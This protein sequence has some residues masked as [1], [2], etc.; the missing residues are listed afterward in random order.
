MKQHLLS[1]AALALSLQPATAE[2]PTTTISEPT[3]V[4]VST[5]F[6]QPSPPTRKGAING[7][8]AGI[9]EWSVKDG[10]LHGDELEENHH[11]SSCTY[12]FEATDM[13]ITAQFRLGT[14]TQIA[15]ACHDTVPPNNHLGR[16]FISKDAIWVTRMSGI[17]KTTKSEKLAELKTPID[18]EA[19]HTITIEICGDHYRAKVD[20]HV[21]EAHHE[22]YKDA[23]GIVALIN[24]GQGAQFKN[25]SIW[26]AKAKSQSSTK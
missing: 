10:A 26:H 19:W 3:K 9:G 4:I 5:P 25:V 12:R 8:Q 6:D 24:K 13:I 16:T 20:D 23:K 15:F 22:R 14:A 11:P 1:L 21:V 7:W 2:T 18:P 17:S